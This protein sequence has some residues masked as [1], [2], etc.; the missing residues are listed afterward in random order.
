MPFLQNFRIE[1]NRNII[2]DL[3]CGSGKIIESIY[4]ILNIKYYGIDC[5]SKV[6]LRN[7]IKFSEP[8][9]TFI[10]LHSICG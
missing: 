1:N 4:D 9:Y 6:I 8:K 5:Y 10:Y 2:C 3:G 7:K